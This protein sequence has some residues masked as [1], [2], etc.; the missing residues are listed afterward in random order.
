MV[1]QNL[2]QRLFD[3]S[4]LARLIIDASTD[5]LTIL[6]ANQAAAD[7]LGLQIDDLK[8][9]ALEPLLEA[10]NKE[11]ILRAF[12]VSAASGVSVT[13]QLIPVLPGS[14]RIQS[15][16]LNPLS[17]GLID[18]MARPPA[19][20]EDALRRERDDAMSIFTSV[21]DASDVGIL[22]TDHNRRIVRVNTTF[23]N[24]YG[25]EP[26]KLIGSDFTVLLPESERQAGKDR[27][28]NFMA[29]T[30]SDRSF[31]LE[32]LRGD[33]GTAN[34]IASSG[35]IELSGKRKF[36]ITTIVDITHLKNIESDL[37]RARDAADAANRAK[38]AFL[39]NMSHELRTPLNAVIGFSDLMLAGM[40]G[41]IENKQY[42]SYIAD[43]H[44]SA[45]HLLSIINDVLDMSK[46]EAG[47][48]KPDEN[49]INLN[50]V[51][52]DATR[53]MTAKAGERKIT[54]EAKIPT[55]PIFNGDERMIRQVFLNLLS[56]AVKFSH[57]GGIIT[58]SAQNLPSGDLAITVTDHGIGIPQDRLEEALQPFGQVG[59][60][61]VAKGQ[62]TGLG[63]P[64][65]RTMLELHGGGL[66]IA[67]QEGE[68]TSVTCL[69]PHERLGVTTTA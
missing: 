31:E 43:I 45:T 66:S 13:A 41:E 11:H 56:N 3:A 15:F 4:P 28:V 68:G 51:L 37:R 14:V 25:W 40:F 55:L 64:L 52:D 59:D 67:S 19:S 32:I 39:A 22:V 50:V 36:R 6:D 69:F 38:S 23:C 42:K 1:D 18:M 9:H 27:H 54:L 34:I 61:R 20:D 65:A 33:S 53:L 8:N 29:G 10:A 48:M 17:G 47:G 49:N 35:V 21:F 62:G 60:P 46:I 16:I 30:A 58:L 26:I 57:E 12:K 44:F 63:L 24:A 5:S 2:Y 7:Y